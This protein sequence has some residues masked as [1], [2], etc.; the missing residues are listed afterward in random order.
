MQKEEVKKEKSKNNEKSSFSLI[1]SSAIIVALSSVLGN[2]L[3]F[4][5]QLIAAKKLSVEDFGKF[6]IGIMI[7]GI[8][9]IIAQFGLSH[10]LKRYA[11]KYISLKSLTKLKNS[12]LM[13]FFAILFFG[14]LTSII[15]YNMSGFIAEY[16]FK[17]SSIKTV[18]EIFSLGILPISL[19]LVFSEALFAFKK[20]MLKAASEMIEK[21]SKIG[22][23]FIAILT[24]GLTVIYASYSYIAGIMAGC[25]AALAF[26]YYCYKKTASKLS[27]RH[28]IKESPKDYN[29]GK[30]HMLKKILGFSYPLA[31]TA[32]FGEMMR[33]TDKLV[34]GYFLDAKSIGLYS[35]AFSLAG[36]LPVISTSLSSLYIPIASDYLA[37]KKKESVAELYIAITKAS[38]ILTMPLAIIAAALPKHLLSYI[39]KASYAEAWASFALLSLA[40]LAAA[41]FG[42]GYLTLQ[43]FG[44]T[45]KI[46]KIVSSTLL[47][48]SLLNIAFV[49]ILGISGI[50]LATLVAMALQYFILFKES[51]KYLPISIK[52]YLISSIK[53]FSSGFLAFLALAMLRRYATSIIPAILVIIISVLIYLALLFVLKALKKDEI[54]LLISLKKIIKKA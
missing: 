32:A 8:G 16:F 28:N 44:K 31:F 25:T 39:Y 12:M 18:I 23:L 29:P 49:T 45:K 36:F 43:L 48:N 9:S 38:L 35:V 40:F 15:F 33:R 10:G 30:L 50:A 20:P 24:S 41:M 14:S 22:F 42:P 3:S 13:S 27:S 11:S 52:S 47:L 21:T 6:S 54:K 5:F 17:D 7:L 19:F 34:I 51:A 37:K 53:P 4:L 1:L 46:F 2:I 26:A